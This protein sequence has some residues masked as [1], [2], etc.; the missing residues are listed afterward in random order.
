[1]TLKTRNLNTRTRR[2][3]ARFTLPSARLL[4]WTAHWRSASVSSSLQ[5]QA[6]G[7]GSTPHSAQSAPTLKPQ[8]SGHFHQILTSKRKPDL[9]VGK[10]QK[11]HSTLFRSKPDSSNLRTVDKEL[12]NRAPAWLTC[13]ME[14]PHRASLLLGEPASRRPH[15]PLL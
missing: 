7:G 8:I 12:L 10:T 2:C 5:G 1:M 11:M 4:P 14:P 3:G 6:D 15:P 9:W 13:G